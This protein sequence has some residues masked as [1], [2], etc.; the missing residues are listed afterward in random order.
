MELLLD[1]FFYGTVI[2]VTSWLGRPVWFLVQGIQLI[3]FG[4]VYFASPSFSLGTLLHVV[5]RSQLVIL[6]F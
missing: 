5:Y 1:I 6:R 2:L 3:G 4:L